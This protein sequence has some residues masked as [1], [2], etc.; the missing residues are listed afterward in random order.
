M[1]FENTINYLLADIS[2]IHRTEM[3]AVL[4]KTGIH[5]GQVFVLFE[6]WKTDGLSQIDLA[7]NL[8]ISAPT[9]NKLVKGLQSGGFIKTKRSLTDA[10]MVNIFLTDKG[11]EI[12][13]E[14]EN[15]WDIFEKSVTSNL[16]ET[17]K[18]ILLQLLKK[19]LLNFYDENENSI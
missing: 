13:A 4:S 7:K 19:I 2:V 1:D 12:R 15:V 9:V 10:R 6:L 14:I 16:T 17:E 3:E 8:Y 5:S 18:L 11:L